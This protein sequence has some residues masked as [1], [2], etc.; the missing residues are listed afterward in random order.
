MQLKTRV[1]LCGKRRQETWAIGTG[2]VHRRQ[3][4]KGASLPF[5]PLV[6]SKRL[7]LIPSSQG[8]PSREVPPLKTPRRGRPSRRPWT[9]HSLGEGLAGQVLCEV[10]AQLRL[11]CTGA[12]ICWVKGCHNLSALRHV[13]PFRLLGLEA[14]GGPRICSLHKAGQSSQRLAAVTPQDCG[15]QRF[16]YGFTLC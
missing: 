2:N 10:P 13:S 12:M 16:V 4:L 3:A 11:R 1:V 6:R 14:P 7:I 8:K 15:G 5:L 9:G